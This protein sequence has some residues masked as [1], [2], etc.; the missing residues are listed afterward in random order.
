MIGVRASYDEWAFK[1]DRAEAAV[2]FDADFDRF[3]DAIKTQ[4]VLCFVD[5]SQEGALQLFKLHFVYSAFENG[6]LHALAHAFASF[7]DAPQAFAPGSAFGRY[8][9]GDDDEHGVIILPDRAG[10][11]PFRRE[12]FLP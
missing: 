2:L 8:V 9:V 6:F 12:W 1:I 4:V 11:F 7:G 3:G 5:F 10:S